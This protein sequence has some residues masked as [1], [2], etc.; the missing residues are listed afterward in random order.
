MPELPEVETIRRGL[1]PRL[2]G[3]TID[4]AEVRAEKLFVGD[5][6]SLVGASVTRI[7][8]YGKLLVFYF[9]N[10]LALTVHL[11]MTGQL[12]WRG[13]GAETV[14]GGHPE[15]SYIDPL[16]HKHTWIIL[17]F[18]DNSV[19]YFNDLRKFGQ[20]AVL[21]IEE[22]SVHSFIKKL[23][24]EPLS[25]EFTIEFLEDLLARRPK[26]VMKS[27]LLDQ[28]RIAGLGNIYVDE[29]LFRAG[30]MPT[31]LA[32]S[33]KPSEIRILHDAIQ[34]TIELAL[35]NG[36]SSERDY[37]NAIG[38]KGT[39]IQIA[40]VYRRTGLICKVC[41]ESPILRMKIGGRSTHYCPVCQK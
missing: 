2:I 11:K 33:L 10:E 27:L 28:E 8:R 20:M 31:R 3:R 36:G 18:V 1:E 26:Q 6:E 25:P 34:V 13:E 5:P 39:Y 41:G 19:M 37:L 14:A 23:G 22:L 35:S 9:D 17:H 30:I 7:G 21:R 40:N 24:P 38:E 4:R 12:I 15:K 16:P 29:S 32:G